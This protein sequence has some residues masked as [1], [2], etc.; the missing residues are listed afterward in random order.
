MADNGIEM[1]ET[2]P[3]VELVTRGDETKKIR[4]LINHNSQDT[5]FGEIALKPF[6][7]RVLTDC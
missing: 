7:C 3:G 2:P 5:A 1:V 6:E 4:I